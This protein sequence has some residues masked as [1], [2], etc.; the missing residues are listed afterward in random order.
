MCW[1]T[2]IDNSMKPVKGQMRLG[3]LQGFRLFPCR[4]RCSGHQGDPDWL[5][6]GCTE[7]VPGWCNTINRFI[8]EQKVARP[9]G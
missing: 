3:R 7:S 6:P 8:P 9:V 1:W 5:V 4:G 2:A